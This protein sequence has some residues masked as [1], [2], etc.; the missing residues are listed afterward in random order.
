MTESRAARTLAARLFRLQAE[1]GE[2]GLLLFRRDTHVL[3]EWRPPG[4]PRIDHRA[5]VRGTLN[6]PYAMAHCKTHSQL[7]GA[8]AAKRIQVDEDVTFE[9]RQP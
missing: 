6:A 4:N 5:V 3:G 8:V 1:N 2:E 9:P 7:Y